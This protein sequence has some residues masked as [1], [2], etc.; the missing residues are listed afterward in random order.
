MSKKSLEQFFSRPQNLPQIPQVVKELIETFDDPDTDV[1]SVAK[2]IGMDAV[3]TANTLKLANSARYGRSRQVATVN[4]AA[5]R[6]GLDVLR[7]MVLAAGLVDM[8]PSVPHFD[9]KGFW[10]Q[11]FNVGE[12]CRLLA[13]KAQC[14]SELGFTCGM[15]H[16]IGELII[17]AAEPEL[18]A[19]LDSRVAAGE[20]RAYAE[21]AVLG[22]TYAEV[23]AELANRWLFPEVIQLA[24]RNQRVP[25]LAEPFSQYAALVYMAAYLERQEEAG[26]D[27][28]V[29]WPLQ[30]AI[31]L[32]IDWTFARDAWL[33][34][35]EEGSAYS[36][37]LGE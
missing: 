27:Q 16:N 26:E 11:A 31:K 3:I 19:E 33:K 4:D 8:Y 15:L 9:L 14:D 22:F 24:I 10:Q 13:G 34:V 2:K 32:K 25:L 12:L 23:G 35:K 29:D 30:L 1:R 21:H 17:H 28:P 7:N 36:M 5:V 37:L 6:L 18:A 20:A